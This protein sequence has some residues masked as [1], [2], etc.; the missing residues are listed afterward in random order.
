MKKFVLGIVV[1]LIACISP[2]FACD[3]VQNV[4]VVS[5]YQPV[6]EV[7]VQ[8]V[9]YVP[10]QVQQVNVVRNVQVVNKVVEV[11]KVQKVVNVQRNVNVQRVRSVNR[12][13]SIS[14]SVSR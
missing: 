8:A 12:S 14:R 11:Q 3:H 1:T 10:I 9:E 6:V 4:Q 13:F 2:I 7:R 5:T